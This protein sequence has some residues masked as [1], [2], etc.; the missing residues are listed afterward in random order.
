MGHYSTM[1]ATDFRS[2]LSEAEMQEAWEG[3]LQSHDEHNKY[4]LEI[5][6]ILK[7]HEKEKIDDEYY[8]HMDDYLAKHSAYELLLKFISNVIKPGTHCV[9]EFYDGDD[10][11]W[12]W[13]I[14]QNELHDIEY[15]TMVNGMPIYD[16]I[17][18]KREIHAGDS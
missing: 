15:T 6:E 4:S 10:E 5:Y 11:R 3:Y 7:V 12:G 1:K 18:K 16:F 17:E 9:I 14:Y 2:N 13:L 8:I